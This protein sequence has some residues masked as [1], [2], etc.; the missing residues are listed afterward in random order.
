[1]GF[2]NFFAVFSWFLCPAIIKHSLIN[3][4][5]LFLFPLQTYLQ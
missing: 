2:F 5:I 1:L 4:Q 3:L